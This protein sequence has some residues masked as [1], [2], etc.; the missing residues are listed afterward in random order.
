[1]NPELICKT[2]MSATSIVGSIFIA[3]NAGSD[4]AQHVWGVAFFIS[5]IG[6]SSKLVKGE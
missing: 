6:L 1:M 4:I 5:G 2:L 3:M